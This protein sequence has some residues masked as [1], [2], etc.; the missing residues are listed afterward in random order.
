MPNSGRKLQHKFY[1]N[2]LTGSQVVAWMRYTIKG[3][4]EQQLLRLQ[5]HL[6]SKVNNLIAVPWALIRLFWQWYTNHLDGM[7]GTE[8]RI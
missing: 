1:E 7:W 4:R 3:Q 8:K 5:F 6:N 2:P